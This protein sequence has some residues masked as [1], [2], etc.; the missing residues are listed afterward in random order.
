MAASG[1]RTTTPKMLRGPA[2]TARA[3]CAENYN[4]HAAPLHALLSYW[5]AVLLARSPP[6]VAAALSVSMATS[7]QMAAARP[8]WGRDR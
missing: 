4:S 1:R 2:D 6:S 3:R 5:L 7:K 8:E